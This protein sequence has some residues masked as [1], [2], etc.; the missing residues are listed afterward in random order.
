MISRH[1][2]H[3][4][5]WDWV[6]FR[7]YSYTRCDTS[8]CSGTNTQRSI[9]LLGVGREQVLDNTAFNWFHA[10][11]VS[12]C[13]YWHYCA[14]LLL[15]HWVCF[16]QWFFNEDL[17]IDWDVCAIDQVWLVC[18]A[19]HCEPQLSPLSWVF[20]LVLSA[21]SACLLP[22]FSLSLFLSHSLFL[23]NY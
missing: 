20:V 22:S 11:V 18:S 6:C 12:K 14:A 7:Q 5:I 1:T 23:L 17:F 8:V 9:S 15:M 13:D 2:K 21:A 16:I 19:L 4:K 10:F 3:K